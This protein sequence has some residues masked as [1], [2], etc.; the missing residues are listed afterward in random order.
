MERLDGWR[1]TPVTNQAIGAPGLKEIRKLVVHLWVKG[2][3][4]DSSLLSSKY[5]VGFS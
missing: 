2:V 4:I 3:G 1:C 5:S